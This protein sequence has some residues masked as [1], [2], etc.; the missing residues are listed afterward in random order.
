MISLKAYAP[1]AT[2]CLTSKLQL[3]YEFAHLLQDLSM[4]LGSSADAGTE[5]YDAG[6]GD[7][8]WDGYGDGADG[9]DGYG[10]GADS[11][12]GYGDGAHGYDGYDGY[13]GYPTGWQYGS[14]YGYGVSAAKGGEAC[15]SEDPAE[16]EPDQVALSLM[17]SVL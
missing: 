14:R 16:F 15:E 1:Q 9:W 12:G 11:W 5:S 2:R 10:D 3:S 17:F 7:A 4:C 8:S 6:D 13:A